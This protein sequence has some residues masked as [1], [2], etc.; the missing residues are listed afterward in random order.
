MSLDQETLVTTIVRGAQRA[1]V[2]L[3]SPKTTVVLLLAVAAVLAWANFLEAKHGSAYA[4]WFVYE[5][6]GFVGLL[7]L[8]GINI[9]CAAASRWPWKRHH[10]TL[11]TSANASGYRALLIA[12]C[13][14][15]TSRSAQY[16]ATRP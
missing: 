4:R 10:T 15:P 16:V 11:C 3:A 5:S 9:F 1:F 7:A 13:Y 14:C 12:L 6:A 2:L 8:L